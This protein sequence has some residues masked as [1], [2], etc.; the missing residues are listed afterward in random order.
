VT[1]EL[2]ASLGMYDFPWTASANDALWAALGKRLRAAG[3]AAPI[4]LTRGDDL[5]ALWRSPGLIFGQTCGFPYITTLRGHAALT[6][7]P[8]YAFPGC[9]GAAHRSFVVA[10][11]QR[12][13]RTLA[14]F[15]GA[16]AGVNAADSN[17]GMNL[18]RATVAPL[19]RGRPFF[20]HVTVTGSHERSLEAVRNGAVD[21]AAIDCV[22]FGLLGRGRPDL[23]HSVEIIA[24]SP[25]S[26]GLPFIMSATLAKTRLDAVR[27]ALFETL[28]DPA[29]A[30]AREALGLAGAVVLSDDDYRRVMRIE[31]RAIAADYPTLA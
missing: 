31:Q 23:T 26:P 27:A 28:T 21:V 17:S 25:F 24:R 10:R 9:R 16:R 5:H 7:T 1:D 20:A 13:R 15:A 8:A 6:A 19:A 18:F 3:I 14:D 30:G 11:K 22:S 4:G 29:F 2:V 12:T